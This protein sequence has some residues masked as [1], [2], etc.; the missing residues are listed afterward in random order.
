MRNRHKRLARYRLVVCPLRLIVECHL[1]LYEISQK[2]NVRHRNI[3]EAAAV[4]KKRVHSR[5][6]P[7]TECLVPWR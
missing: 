2:A 1:E 7:P 5:R 3:Y 4:W 6:L